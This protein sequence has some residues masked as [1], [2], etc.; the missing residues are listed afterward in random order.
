ML[1]ARE[2][3]RWE[4]PDPREAEV[5]IGVGMGLKRRDNVACAVELAELLGG[6]VAA[7]RNAVPAGWILYHV[8]VGASGKAV[9]P[10]LYLALGVG[11]DLNHLVAIRRAKYVA[12]VNINKHADIFK[13]AN[14]GVVGDAVKISQ[15][16]IELLKA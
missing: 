13:A 6:A 16:L 1:T 9:A 11:G 5:V 2:A 8:Q 15:L 14:L 4:L 3:A 12:A 7:T 10:H